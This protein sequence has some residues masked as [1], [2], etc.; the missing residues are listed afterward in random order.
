M[1]IKE[2]GSLTPTQKMQDLIDLLSDELNIDLSNI[3]GKSIMSYNFEHIH[4][5]LV[6][7][8]TFSKDY[9]ERMNPSRR[10]INSDPAYN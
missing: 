6:V 2:Y 7:L 9:M 5:F 4:K 10:R 1:K 3:S 8:E